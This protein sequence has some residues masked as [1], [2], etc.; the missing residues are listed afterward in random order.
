[1][2]PTDTAVEKALESLEDTPKPEEQKPVETPTEETPEEGKDPKDPKEIEGF[3]AADVEEEVEEE[4]APVTPA[5]LNTDGLTPEAKYIVDN[6]PYITARIKQGSEVKD[7]QIKSWTQLPEEVEFATKR[8]ELAFMN[9][10]T[11]QEN[12]ALGLQ[13]QFQQNQ[14]TEQSKDFETRE[15]AGIR[16]D[17]TELQTAGDIPKFKVKSSDP[18]F[19]KDPATQEVQKIIDFMTERNEQ[20]LKEYNQGRPYRHIGFKEAYQM[21]ERTNPKETEQQQEDKAR[22]EVADKTT[23]NRGLSSRELKKPTIHSGTRID[24]ILDRIDSEEW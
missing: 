4:A 17:I 14:K 15:N 1:M 9:A 21:R 16:D 8:D 23:G 11:A 19:S 20:Y 5:P 22:K 7:V 24:Q 13:Q 6:L 3:T 2:N 18:S 12:R 10:I